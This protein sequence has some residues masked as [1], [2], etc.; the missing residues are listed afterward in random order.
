LQRKPHPVKLTRFFGNVQ[1]H[2]FMSGR[3]KLLRNGVP[4]SEADAPE[5]GYEYDV[6]GPFDGTCGTYGLDEFQLPHP[7]CPETYI[8]GLEDASSNSS[9]GLQSYAACTNAMNCHMFA[10]MTT[11]VKAGSPT[12]LF[13]HQVSRIL[14]GAPVERRMCIGKSHSGQWIAP[15]LLPD[16]CR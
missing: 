5:L 7:Q 14:C 8:C 6:P 13:I 3:I 10:G 1:I 11:G 2:Q 16:V 4:I 15:A 12:A 9:S